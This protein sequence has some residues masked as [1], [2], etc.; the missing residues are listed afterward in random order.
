MYRH[1]KL[2]KSNGTTPAIDTGSIAA[3]CPKLVPN[4]KLY[5][6]NTSRQS[7]RSSDGIVGLRNTIMITIENT[8]STR[9]IILHLIVP[10]QCTHHVYHAKAT[11]LDILFNLSFQCKRPHVENGIYIIRHL[12]SYIGTVAYSNVTPSATL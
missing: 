8:A 3:G 5:K 10:A 9:G 4:S 11:L 2:Y 12:M 6:L 1:W 7:F